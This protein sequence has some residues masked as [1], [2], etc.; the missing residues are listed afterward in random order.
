MKAIAQ[1]REITPAFAGVFLGLFCY[2]AYIFSLSKIKFLF[3][4]QADTGNP[5]L[6]VV[7]QN[8]GP[9]D[10]WLDAGLLPVFIVA[11]IYILN[12]ANIDSSEECRYI[13]FLKSA[14]IGFFLYIPLTIIA[15][16]SGINLSDKVTLTAGYVLVSIIYFIIRKGDEC[17]KSENGSEI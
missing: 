17:S 2:Y 9:V 8:W 7:A 3:F 11:G 13:S 6:I 12:K 15:Y 14:L 16:V 5:N 1:L 10:Y 4:S